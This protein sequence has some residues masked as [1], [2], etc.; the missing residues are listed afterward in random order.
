MNNNPTAPSIS[1][2]LPVYNGE[3]YLETTLTSIQSQTH[4]DFEVLC[5]NDGSTDNSLSILEEFSQADTRFHVLTQENSGP[6]AARN[7]GLDAATGTYVIMLDADDIYEPTLLE[8]L[9][10]SAEAHGSDVAVCR[11]SQF[12]DSTGAPVDSWWTINIAQIPDMP[13]FNA[14]DMRDFIFTAFIGWPWDKLYRRSFIEEN[15]IRYPRL[16]NSEDLY[17]VFLSLALASKI[18]IVDTPLISHRV[19]RSGSVSGS[20]AKDPLAFY[21]STCLLK[22]Q[23][24]KRPGLYEKTSWGFLNWAI[25]YLV[26]NIETMDDESGRQIQ[27]KALANDEFP[28]LEIGLHSPAFFG[29]E[30]TV[31]ARYCALLDEAIGNDGQTASSTKQQKRHRIIPRLIKFLE[32]IQYDGLLRTLRKSLG[33]FKRKLLKQAVSQPS[34]HIARG[35]DFALTGK[36]AAKNTSSRTLGD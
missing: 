15:A 24:K 36:I 33:W 35:S 16:S 30:P 4:T 18:S 27:L 21:E 8:E 9:Y 17:F 2:V 32:G 3:S 19:N 13:V 10:A 14:A 22:A 6:G 11:S 31:Y 29:L 12:D 34:S 20:R 26:W 23:L 7:T 1:I 25:G 5:V 28:E